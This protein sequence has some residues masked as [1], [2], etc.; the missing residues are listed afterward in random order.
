[1]GKVLRIVYCTISSH[2]SSEG[3]QTDKR[4][5][6]FRYIPRPSTLM[7]VLIFQLVVAA[8]RNPDWISDIKVTNGIFVR[9]SALTVWVNSVCVSNDVLS[10][11]LCLGGTS[12]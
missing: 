3:R 4:E 1:M 7:S 11:L 12:L 2:L 10:N 5:R 6:V 8:G 9:I